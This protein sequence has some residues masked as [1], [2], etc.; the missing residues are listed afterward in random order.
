MSSLTLKIGDYTVEAYQ[1]EPYATVDIV[2]YDDTTCK[3]VPPELY[4][5][6]AAYY[7]GKSFRNTMAETLPEFKRICKAI[8]DLVVADKMLGV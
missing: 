3:I 4:D 1:E 2:V 5:W 8:E 6:K 7:L